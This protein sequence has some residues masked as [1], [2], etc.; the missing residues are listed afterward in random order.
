MPPDHPAIDEFVRVSPSPDSVA[1]DLIVTENITV[2]LAPSRLGQI[3]PAW[4]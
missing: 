3:I 4:P 1:R 2:D